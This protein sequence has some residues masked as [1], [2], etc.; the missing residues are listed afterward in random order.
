MQRIELTRQQLADMLF[1]QGTSEFIRNHINYGILQ[2]VLRESGSGRSMILT[3]SKNGYRFE[4]LC[5]VTD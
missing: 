2:S 4:M 5:K 1:Y 3:F